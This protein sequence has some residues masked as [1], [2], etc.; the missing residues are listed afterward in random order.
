MFHY[1][2]CNGHEKGC[3]TGSGFRVQG[4]STNTSSL[5]PAA[6]LSWLW[7]ERGDIPLS[8]EWNLSR[9][10]L[11]GAVWVSGLLK[12]PPFPFPQNKLEAVTRRIKERKSVEGLRRWARLDGEAGRR[13]AVHSTWQFWD[14]HMSGLDANQSPRG[15]YVLTQAGK[16]RQLQSLTQILWFLPQ[17]KKRHFIDLCFFFKDPS[18]CHLEKWFKKQP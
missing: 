15:E 5:R 17:E 4:E 2:H 8:Q 11:Q 10:F 1:S 3:I 18:H 6:L 7:E 13:C 16:S 9:R 12:C 14:S